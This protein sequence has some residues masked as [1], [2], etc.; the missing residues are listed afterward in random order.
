MW[1]DLDFSGIERGDEM[2]RAFVPGS[3][4]YNEVR[5]LVS[6]KPR[7][8][9][10]L[11]DHAAKRRRTIEGSEEEKNRQIA[12]FYRKTPVRSC[13]DVHTLS[14]KPRSV[15]ETALIMKCHRQ[16]DRL[17]EDPSL[18]EPKERRRRRAISELE[19]Y[20]D[21]DYKLI[22]VEWVRVLTSERIL[23]EQNKVLV[24]RDSPA[25][26]EPGRDFTLSSFDRSAGHGADFPY[27]REAMLGP[28]DPIGSSRVERS[29]REISEG[30]TRG[31]EEPPGLAIRRPRSADCPALPG[32]KPPGLPPPP[33][34]SPPE[35][36]MRGIEKPPGPAAKRP[37]NAGYSV[38]PGFMPPPGLPPP[39]GHLLFEDLRAMAQV[40]K[41]KKE[42]TESIFAP[43]AASLAV[44]EILSGDAGSEVI[45]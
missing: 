11:H 6:I 21:V 35:G 45:L 3:Q 38:P 30:G 41:N 36:E 14:R 9:Y 43:A 25:E 31:L 27:I 37:R 5:D 7:T 42:G 34:L 19:V 24:E 13:L 2:T 28:L 18:G 29:S 12:N 10:D 33:G 39:P 22:N 23:A 40:N 20:D 4:L 15:T 44:G 16:L 17:K 8:V 1:R 32:F 26:V